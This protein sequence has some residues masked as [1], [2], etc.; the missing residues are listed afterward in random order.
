[1]FAQPRLA[2]HNCTSIRLRQPHVLAAMG[3]GKG[4]PRGQ[5]KQ[6]RKSA[7]QKKAAKALKQHA[8]SG[9]PHHGGRGRNKEYRRRIQQET[10]QLIGS[11]RIVPRAALQTAVDA[12]I[13]SNMQDTV[14]S[15]PAAG[16]A[17]FDTEVTVTNE[18]CCDCAVRLTKDLCADEPRV[19]M[20]NMASQRNPGGGYKNGAQAQVGVLAQL[21]SDERCAC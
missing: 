16:Q 20:L 19:C 1:M 2:F 3:R 6:L 10:L 11:G 17:R 14:D 12:C 4:E 15:K 9:S 8:P 5:T 18:D 7:K 13:I 21:S